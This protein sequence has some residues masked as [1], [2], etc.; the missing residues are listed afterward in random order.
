[1]KGV[2]ILGIGLIAA[3]AG[4]PAL[5]DTVTPEEISA[6][7]AAITRQL[8]DPAS[9]QFKITTI[10]HI[11]SAGAVVFCGFVNAKNQFGGYTGFRPFVLFAGDLTI[12]DGRPGTGPAFAQL[13][14]LMCGTA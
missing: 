7:Q 8:A 1:M 5:A 12:N 11:G 4:Q 10:R 9:A 14:Q 13:Q 2:G 3:M 6:A